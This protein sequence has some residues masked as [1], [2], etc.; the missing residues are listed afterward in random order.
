MTERHETRTA[1]ENRPNVERTHE[2]VE[3]GSKWHDKWSNVVTVTHEDSD[4]VQWDQWSNSTT[5]HW[6]ASRAQW[7]WTKRADGWQNWDEWWN[8]R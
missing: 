7:E 1:V 8:N 3:V 4:T 6:T 5:V 2:T